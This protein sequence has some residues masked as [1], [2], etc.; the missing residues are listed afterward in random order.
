MP[1]GALGLPHLTE[2]SRTTPPR[3]H[4][5]PAWPKQKLSTTAATLGNYPGE[6]S[7]GR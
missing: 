1:R 2:R 4:G 5:Q 3:G 6:Y 7:P